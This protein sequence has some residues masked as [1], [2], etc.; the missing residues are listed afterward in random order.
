M[1]KKIISIKSVGKFL[2]YSCKGDV[3]FE[4]LTLIFGENGRGKTMLSALL[5][6]L[7]S[8]DPLFLLERK[9]VKSASGPEA[10]VLVDATSHVFKDGKWNDAAPGILVFD[11]TFINENVY[12]GIYVDHEHKRNLYRFIVGEAGVKLASAVDECD[13][14][15]RDKNEEIKSKGKELQPLVLGKLEVKKF[16]ELV[17]IPDVDKKIGEKETEVAALK[18]ASVIGKKPALA[19]LSLPSISLTEIESLMGKKIEDIAENAEKLTKQHIA[20]CMD[21]KGE[22]WVNDGLGYIKQ[23]RCP[24]C[25]QSL[26]GQELI[27]AYRAYFSAA[28]TSL[29]TEIGQLILKVKDDFSQEAILHLQESI[30]SNM[31]NSDFWKDYVNSAY[32]SVNFENLKNAWTELQKAVDQDLQEKKASPLESLAPGQNTRKA[33][34][35]FEAEANGVAAYNA[36]VDSINALIAD[37]KKKTAGGNLLSAEGELEQLKN[38]KNRHND[39]SIKGMCDDYTKLVQEKTTIEDDKAK[40]KANLETYAKTVLTKY[41]KNIN[42]YLEDF[43]AGFKICNTETKYPGGKPTSD[44]QLSIDNIAVNLGDSKPA[45]VGPCFKNTLSAGDKSTLA[46]AFFVARLED[47]SNP[48]DKLSDK[49]VVLDDPVSSLDSNRRHCTQ[50]V[51]RQLSQK[52]Q[53]VIVLSHDSQFLLSIWSN[54]KKLH[55]KNLQIARSGQ[56]SKIA[57]WDIEKG[58]RDTYLHCYFT[59]DE[60]IEKGALATR[61]IAACIRLLL[62]GNLRVRFPK[63]FKR[64]EWLGDFIEKIHK[65]DPS[66]PLAILKASLPELEQINEYSKKFH[67]DQNPTGFDKAPVNDAELQSYAKRALKFC[68]GA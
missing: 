11:T 24:F 48:L 2:D 29:K 40:A 49:V 1:I 34:T 14:K 21:Q 18:H 47:D 28:Y 23:D 51:I 26:A 13:A 45:A 46:F 22:S 16:V 60:Y 20:S 12:S 9:S 8:G 6:S 54:E 66:A 52:A 63:E 68:C 31:S 65:S 32:P 33:F 44:Y 15:I 3:G 67:H 43:G 17:A 5:R 50:Q 25:G 42:K 57:E 4:K 10:S 19:K 7:D 38:V 58:T 30:S 61:E 55:P 35:A 39:L 64:N 36:Q 53:Q 37:K 56:E 41:E 59:L 62:E 27:K